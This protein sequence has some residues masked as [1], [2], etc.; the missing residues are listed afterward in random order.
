MVTNL[1]L[2]D[3]G[4]RTQDEIRAGCNSHASL[5]V[6]EGTDCLMQGDKTGRTGCVESY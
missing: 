6:P 1:G 5:V 2:A 4:L 3:E